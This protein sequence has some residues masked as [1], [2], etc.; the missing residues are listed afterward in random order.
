MRPQIK[1]VELPAHDS[2]PPH[3]CI[4]TARRDGELVDFGADFKGTNPH[5]YI[6]R[7][8]VE[9]A[10]TE[11]LGMVPQKTV[12]ALQTEL[13]EAQ[14]ERDRLAAIV[15][16]GQDLSAAEERLREALGPAPTLEVSQ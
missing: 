2:K 11:V 15:A 14:D 13:A 8:I 5:V 9:R 6:R 7:Q 10:G 16:G 1:L 12:N 3:T 4:V